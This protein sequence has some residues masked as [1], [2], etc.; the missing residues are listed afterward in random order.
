MAFLGETLSVAQ[1]ALWRGWLRLATLSGIA[2]PITEKEP[3]R[4]RL[5]TILTA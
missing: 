5:T 3:R 4:H 2:I 1:P